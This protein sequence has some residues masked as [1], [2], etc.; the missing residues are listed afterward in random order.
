MKDGKQGKDDNVGD[1]QAEVWGEADYKIISLGPY[2][3]L[4]LTEVVGR[5][6]PFR[7]FLT[8]EKV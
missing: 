5:S 6:V 3:R 4:V 1:G 2:V 8:S 7:G